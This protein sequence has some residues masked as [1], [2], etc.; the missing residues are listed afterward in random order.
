MVVAMSPLSPI[1][2][3][4]TSWARVPAHCANAA[5]V[6]AF[7]RPPPSAVSSV[8]S[9][10][11]KSRAQYMYSRALVCWNTLTS[12]RVTSVVSS[13]TVLSKAVL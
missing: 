13:R 4:S 12:S 3:S 2:P 7:R 8:S 6:P 5:R 1:M 11:M 10:S 9:R